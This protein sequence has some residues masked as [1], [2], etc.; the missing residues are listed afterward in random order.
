MRFETNDTND[1]DG[2]D[3][4]VH[5]MAFICSCTQLGHI[6]HAEYSDEDDLMEFSF[7]YSLYQYLP[8]WKRIWRALG[9]VFFRRDTARYDYC[10]LH[11]DDATALRNMLDDY[12]ENH[13]RWRRK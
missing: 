9:Y 13:E 6:I 10:S 11:P 3:H 5:R 12:L 8:W 7:C 2:A 4:D 1:P